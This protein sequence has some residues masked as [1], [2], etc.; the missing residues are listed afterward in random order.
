[1]KLFYSPGTSS[2]F[3]HIVLNE[4][5][6]AFELVRVDE[7]RKVMENGGDY[8]TVNPLGYV[9]ALQFPD[10]TVLTEAVA[11]A[12]YVADLVP[13]KKLVPPNST[14]DRAKLNAWLNFLS[15]EV[16][17]GCFCPL[18][19]PEVPDTVK[20]VF[21]RRL[22]TRLAHVEAHLTRNDHLL[23]QTFS[24]ADVYLFVMS[25]WA[26]S[27]NVDL[28]SYPHVLALRRRVGAQ[29]AVQAAMKVEGL[30]R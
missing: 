28:S 25:N 18:Y 10:G 16:Q 27:A 11:I 14:L 6:L 30:A 23:G 7:H 24:V 3:P 17:L 8:R 19:H 1:M 9:P 15:A 22:A 26:R 2:L 12:Q 13:A 5:G 21:R 4:S 29:P 20:S